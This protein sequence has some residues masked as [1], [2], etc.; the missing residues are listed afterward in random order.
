[1][2][3][4]S[5]HGRLTVARKL[6]T[7]AGIWTTMATF[8]TT[9]ATFWI[10]VATS[11]QFLGSEKAPPRSS[12]GARFAK[13]NGL[14]HRPSGPSVLEGVNATSVSLQV[15]SRTVALRRLHVALWWTQTLQP[16]EP[17]FLANLAPAEDRG[18][19]FSLPRNCSEVATVIQNVAT[20][21]QNVAIV[22][23]IPATVFSFLA[24]V[25][26]PWPLSRA[27]YGTI[28]GTEVVNRSRL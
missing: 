16:H 18:G 7:V 22:V 14:P 10:T 24:T 2:A 1:M 26:L 4:Y 17:L 19:A 21:V 13:K 20:V 12:A 3:R 5:G 27:I 9:V 11:E 15:V 25:S 28:E 23:Q 8:W 6:N